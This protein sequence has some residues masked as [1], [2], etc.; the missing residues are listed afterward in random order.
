MD[1]VIDIHKVGNAIAH[2]PEKLVKMKYQGMSEENISILSIAQTVFAKRLFD[3]T[4]SNDTMALESA[5]KKREFIAP[6]WD[7]N[8]V[9]R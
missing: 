5:N 1:G 3:E 2:D 9:G 4:F 6:H 7:F 8:G